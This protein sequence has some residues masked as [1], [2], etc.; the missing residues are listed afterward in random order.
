MSDAD[1][2]V[3]ALTSALCEAGIPAEVTEQSV[4]PY[5][6]LAGSFEDYLKQLDG[7]SRY[8]VSR[9][10]RELEKWAGPGGYELRRADSRE[11]LEEGRRVLQSLHGERWHDRGQ[12]GVF[13]SARFARFHEDVMPRLLAGEDGASLDLLWLVA[14]GEPIAVLYNIVYGGRV[15]FYQSGRKVSL[16]KS[17]RPGIAIHAL[18]IRRAIEQ[19]MKEYDFLGGASQYKRQLGLRERRLVELRG[20][21]RGLRA[22]VI[23]AARGLA[24]NAAARVR[25]HRAKDDPHQGAG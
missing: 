13:A 1:P 17:F 7:P 19:G 20:V 9:S 4:C 21:A 5:I 16:P 25:A 22:R 24:E 10:V 11:T 6:P 3:P 8:L 14:Q 15:H 12:D 18:A 2:F 23:E